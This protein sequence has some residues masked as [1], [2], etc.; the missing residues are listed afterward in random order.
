MPRPRVSLGAVAG[1]LV[2][3]GASLAGAQQQVKVTVVTIPETISPGAC[4]RIWADVKDEQNRQLTFENGQPLQWGS[5]DY[6]TTNG[7]DFEWKSSAS[8]EF[9]LCAKPGVGAVSTEVTA[10]I[11]GMPYSGTTRL[12]V[13]S[14]GATPPSNSGGA[15]PGVASA[16]PPASPPAAAPPAAVPAQPYV[17][18]A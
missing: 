8:G 18:P 4:A 12:A 10:T 2:S 17:P 5:Y 13:A 15:A 7:T 6:S 16:S 11:K 14:Q 1:V 3:L 9:E